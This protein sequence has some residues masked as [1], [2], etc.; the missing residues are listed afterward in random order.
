MARLS[1]AGSQMS[2]RARS[3]SSPAGA[4]G[5]TY[6]GLLLAIVIMGI[7][8]A[9]VGSIWRTQAQ[10]EREEQLLFIGGEYRRAIAA[11]YAT[12]AHQLPQDL[13]DLL[14]DKRG[15]EPR[16]YLRR[17]YAD[18]MTGA[19]DWTILRTD[20]LGISGIASSS[21]AEPLKKKGFPLEELVLEDAT[22]YCDW[23]FV[24]VPRLK[25]SRNRVPPPA[26]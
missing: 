23:K 21:S 3:V 16:H 12:G 15:P 24:Y 18:P 14:E 10:R 9:A 22:C 5:F 11:Y 4:A 6:V 2:C 20:M 26:D 13:K 19:A 25:H 1:S 17:L 8:L 7:G